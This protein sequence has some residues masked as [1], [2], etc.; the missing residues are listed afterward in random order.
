MAETGGGPDALAAVQVEIDRLR[1]DLAAAHERIAELEAQA[2]FDSLLAMFNRRA[3]ER[4]L[5]RSL[6]YVQRYGT[7]ASLVFIDL[8]GFKPVNDRH[9]HAA[10]DA[11]LK[12]V[13]DALSRHVRSSDVV[14]RLGGDEFGVLMWNVAGAE[15]QAKAR[16]LERVIEETSTTHGAVRLGVGAS[17]GVV[18]L[19]TAGSLTQI[20]DAAD[21]AMYVRKRERRQTVTL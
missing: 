7:E 10:G 11:L 8:D 6:A 2:D 5:A 4:E 14:G 1:R 12:A 19:S 3:F 17:A 16:A 18:S 20:L 21:R 9:G 15:A 13:A